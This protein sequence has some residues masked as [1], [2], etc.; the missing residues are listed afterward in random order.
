MKSRSILVAISLLLSSPAFA[1]PTA[2]E[3]EAGAIQFQDSSSFPQ[4]SDALSKQKVVLVGE[5]HGTNEGPQD[6]FKLAQIL[7]GQNDSVLIGLEIPASFQTEM[8]QFMKSGDLGFL[9]NSSWF[10]VPASNQDGRE[11]QAMASLLDN[12]RS[13][14]NVTVFGFDVSSADYASDRNLGMAKN[15]LQ[16]IATV[17]PSVTLILTGNCHSK[18][19][20]QGCGQDIPMAYDLLQNSPELNLANVLSLDLRFESGTAWVDILGSSGP[21][22]VPF[23]E[24]ST[25][26]SQAVSLQSYFFQEPTLTDDGYDG[27]VFERTI[28]ASLPFNSGS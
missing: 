21:T 7:S 11:S 16:E 5:T 25:I 20:K 3:I 10:N 28:S 1:A 22:V 18:L 9:K 17:K 13:L 23:P 14:K 19:S 8:D 27:A 15:L 24:N 12:L 2:A 4:I 6:L 26:Y